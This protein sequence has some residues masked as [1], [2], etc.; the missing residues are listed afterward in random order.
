MRQLSISKSF[1]F[2]TAKVKFRELGDQ[3]KKMATRIS[4]FFKQKVTP[5]FERQCE[6]VRNVAT[7][8]KNG[9]VLKLDRSC[10]NKIMYL[11]REY[12]PDTTIQELRKKAK[13]IEK[14]I[15]ALL[16]NDP[17]S[18]RRSADI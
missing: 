13:S 7:R 6:R 5:I 1:N 4:E 2:E 10:H 17:G 15:V 12:Y 14:K 16:I 8:M 18:G 3:V 11:Y 9:P